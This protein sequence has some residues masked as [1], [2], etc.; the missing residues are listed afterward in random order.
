VRPAARWEERSTLWLTA[1]AG[2]RAEARNSG[3][4]QSAVAAGEQVRGVGLANDRIERLLLGQIVSPVGGG[5]GAGEGTGVSGFQMAASQSDGAFVR[6][7]E[8]GGLWKTP[9][10][11]DFGGGGRKRPSGSRWGERTIRN[12]SPCVNA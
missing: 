11:C 1:R 3:G 5:N 12:A 8:H 9:T 7:G 2:G 4:D 10:S 6:L